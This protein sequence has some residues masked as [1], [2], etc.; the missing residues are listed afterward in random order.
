M[1]TYTTIKYTCSVVCAALH[2]CHAYGA[3]VRVWVGIK[4]CRFNL[5]GIQDVSLNN[6]SLLFWR[7]KNVVNMWAS[8]HVRVRLQFTIEQGISLF[9]FPFNRPDFEQQQPKKERRKSIKFMVYVVVGNHFNLHTHWYWY[10]LTGWRA[11]SSDVYHIRAKRTAY[12]SN[13]LPFPLCFITPCYF[14]WVF[15]LLVKLLSSVCMCS[16]MESQ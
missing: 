16:C 15:F 8:A 11:D 12:T 2:S 3:N 7:K 5:N 6:F 1:T 4:V 14:Q 10:R 9:H 13:D